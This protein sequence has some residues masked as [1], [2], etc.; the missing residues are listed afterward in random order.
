[1]LEK[2]PN[3]ALQLLEKVKAKE[4]ILMRLTERQILRTSQSIAKSIAKGHLFPPQLQ[5]WV[6][7]VRVQNEKKQFYFQ[8]FQP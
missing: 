6:I 5:Y 2:T 8:I 7:S 3:R 4:Q 1:M